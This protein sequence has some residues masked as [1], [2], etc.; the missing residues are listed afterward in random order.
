MMRH[1]MVQMH[2]WANM[3]LRFSFSKEGESDVQYSPASNVTVEWHQFL[4]LATRDMT[5]ESIKN[6]SLLHPSDSNFTQP[7]EY[8]IGM[9]VTGENATE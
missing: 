7:F 8:R 3:L 6:P 4:S 5:I 1:G 2:N 9:R